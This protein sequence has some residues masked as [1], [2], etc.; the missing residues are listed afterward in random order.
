MTNYTFYI[1][2]SN[3]KIKSEWQLLTHKK[4]PHPFSGLS[5]AL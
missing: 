5:T 1:G 3:E 2:R 4:Y